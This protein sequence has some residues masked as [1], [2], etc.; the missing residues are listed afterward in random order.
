MALL[1]SLQLLDH[2]NKYSVVGNEW[3]IQRDCG[4]MFPSYS[5]ARIEQY[6]YFFIPLICD[7]DNESSKQWVYIISK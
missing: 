1:G 3:C 6:F 5:A 2:G 4:V 7:I